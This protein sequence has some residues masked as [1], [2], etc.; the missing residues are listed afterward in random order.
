ML[1]FVNAY[2]KTPREQTRIIHMACILKNS[3]NLRTYAH[4]HQNLV[5]LNL[6]MA[7]LK[8]AFTVGNKGGAGCLR[9]LR[10][11]HTVIVRYTHYTTRHCRHQP[12][13][14]A[15]NRHCP[16]SNH[17]AAAPRL[18]GAT[19]SSHKPPTRRHQI[20]DRAAAQI[21]PS[22][23]PARTHEDSAATRT[24]RVPASAVQLEAP[25]RQRRAP[26]QSAPRGSVTSDDCRRLAPPDRRHHFPGRRPGNRA[27]PRENSRRIPSPFDGRA[28]PPPRHGPAAAVARVL[29]FGRVLKLT[30]E[31]TKGEKR[32]NR[33]LFF[34]RRE[35]CRQ[36]NKYKPR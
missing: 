20:C 13:R 14:Q 1:I 5:K 3:N 9:R 6:G 29:G 30:S 33:K 7:S 36:K 27:R 10:H 2:G 18:P 22:A 16:L 35:N 15:G 11:I 28:P 34:R 4:I 21:R 26:P 31:K 32:E 25:A 24:P 17:R 12:R 23:P 8:D 19:A